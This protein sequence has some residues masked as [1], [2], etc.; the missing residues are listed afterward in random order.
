M[1]S[2]KT[3]ESMQDLLKNSMLKEEKV[4]KIRF[5]VLT[6]MLSVNLLRNHDR[7]ND[8]IPKHLITM[9]IILYAT[10]FIVL[11]ISLVRKFKY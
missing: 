7:E 6:L 5:F 10:N 11:A 2:E 1:K 3:F 8:P 9:Q 4:V